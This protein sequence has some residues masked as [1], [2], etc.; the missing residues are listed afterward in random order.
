ML[1]ATVVSCVPEGT[2]SIESLKIATCALFNMYLQAIQKCYMR[3]YA[4]ILKGFCD[5]SRR[6]TLR[7]F[8]SKMGQCTFWL[9]C[10]SGCT[11]GVKCFVCGAGL[12]IKVHLCK[13]LPKEPTTKFWKLWMSVVSKCHRQ[14]EYIFCVTDFASYFTKGRVTSSLS[15]LQGPSCRPGLAVVS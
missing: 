1:Q 12:S 11:L 3:M 6:G 9:H 8:R 4:N 14:H 7:H 2:Y 10:S 15:C 5:L 13:E